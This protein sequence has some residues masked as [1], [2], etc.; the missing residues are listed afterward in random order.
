VDHLAFDQL[1]DGSLAHGGS[2]ISAMD[3]K[4]LSQFVSP[5]AAEVRAAYGYAKRRGLNFETITHEKAHVGL[6]A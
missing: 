5:R 6:F 4:N 3:E 2:P 1:R